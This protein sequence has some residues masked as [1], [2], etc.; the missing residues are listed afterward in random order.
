MSEK[1][2]DQPVLTHIEKLV[3]EEHQL[4]SRGNQRALT[5]ADQKRLTTIQVELDQCWDLL[6]QRRGLRDAGQD[7]KEAHV[8]PSTVVEG[9]EQ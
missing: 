1:D 4:F 3:T 5:E 7:P 8:R 9:Y 2:T 6:R